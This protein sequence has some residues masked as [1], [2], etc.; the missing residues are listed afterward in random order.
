MKVKRIS[1][2][3]VLVFAMVAGNVFAHDKG[4]LMLNIEPQIGLAF[5]SIGIVEDGI[6]TGDLAD[7]QTEDNSVGVDYGLR[8]TVHYYFWSFFGVNAG[9]GVS[10]LYRVYTFEDT[11]TE[12]YS[13][14]TYKKL[15]SNSFD[16]NLVYITI[17]IGF[18]FSV[19][20]LAVGAGLAINIPIVNKSKFWYEYKETRVTNDTGATTEVA[21]SKSAKE[22]DKD[23]KANTYLGWYADIGFDM[24]GKKG[25]EGGF[26]MLARFSGSLS[27]QVA[28]SKE[29]ALKP[30]E[31]K[32]FSHFAVSLVFQAAIQLANKPIGGK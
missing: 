3:F 2:F 26:G 16:F 8:G 30:Y 10:G 13:D 27:D 15:H 21:K 23:F 31:Y 14:Y 28:K 18:R 29:S 5:P 25:R 1:L 24:S 6:K 32:P 22:S 9:V 4:D 12:E 20:A 11:V 19:S 7:M 17:P